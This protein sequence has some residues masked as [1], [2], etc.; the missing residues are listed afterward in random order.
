MIKLMISGIRGA[1]GQVIM[2]LVSKRPEFE[3][4]AGFDIKEHKDIRTYT[5][6]TKCDE[7][8]D[9]IIDF[10]NPLA[11]NSILDFSL[12]KKI[13]IVIATTGLSPEQI[14]KIEESS[15]KVPVFYA[16]NMSLGVNLL[17]DLVKKAASVLQDNFDIELIEK[18]HNQKIDAPSGTAITIADSINEVLSEKYEYVYDRHN[19]REKRTKKE[20][21]VHTIRGGTIVGEHNVIFSGT[22]EIIE[23]KHTAM[24]KNIFASG[25]LNAA[26]FLYDKKPGLY[27][28]ND[29]IKK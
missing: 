20:I 17:V 25:S 18:H 26:K 12:S 1:M 22:D 2:N 19:K 5:D 14:N 21:G 6:L 4:V 15:K 11:L 10:S 16:S 27:N 23:I 28:M 29:I 7:K 3:L 8:I 9:V 24:S 13:P